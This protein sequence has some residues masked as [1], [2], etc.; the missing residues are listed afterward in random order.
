ME[1]LFNN[2]NVF[3]CGKSNKEVDTEMF[4]QNIY[5]T[6]MKNPIMMYSLREFLIQSKKICRFRQGNGKGW[7]WFKICEQIKN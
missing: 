5:V 2:R 1:N 6:I 7:V 4:I 3:K